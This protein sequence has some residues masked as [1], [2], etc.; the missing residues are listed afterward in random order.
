[1]KNIFDIIKGF[2]VSLPIGI[3]V[4]A[5]FIFG[6]YIFSKIVGWIFNL[7]FFE[8]ISKLL[9]DLLIVAISNKETVLICFAIIITYLMVSYSPTK[10]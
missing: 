8:G 1:M 2:L 3:S 4:G 6:I 7:N 10:K 5:V 9:N